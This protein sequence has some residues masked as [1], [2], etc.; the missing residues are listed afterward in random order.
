MFPRRV[1]YELA[2]D[3]FD[4]GVRYFEVRFAPHLHSSDSLMVGDVV[5]SVN[6]GL[7]KAKEEYNARP[8]VVSGSEPM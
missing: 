1:A 8:A 6:K 2:C 5:Q 3:N 7:Q 4:E